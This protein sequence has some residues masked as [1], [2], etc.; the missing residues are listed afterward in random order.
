MAKL[1]D[2]GEEC[3][4]GIFIGESLLTYIHM[5]MGSM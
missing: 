1:I 4:E 5:N 2:A 3:N